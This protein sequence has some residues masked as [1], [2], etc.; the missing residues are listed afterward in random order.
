MKRNRALYEK[1]RKYQSKDKPYY[2]SEM[3]RYINEKDIKTEFSFNVNSVEFIRNNKPI[4]TSIE[5][6]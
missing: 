6:N 1:K 3:K 5:I 2:L 4:I